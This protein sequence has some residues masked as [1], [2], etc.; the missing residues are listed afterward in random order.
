[1]VELGDPDI[2]GGVVVELG[3]CDF[4]GGGVGGRAR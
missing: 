3:D 4:L 1:M 2:S